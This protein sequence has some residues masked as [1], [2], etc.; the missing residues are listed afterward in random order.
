M[1]DGKNYEDLGDIQIERADDAN[2]PVDIWL[3]QIDKDDDAAEDGRA[4]WWQLRA[5]N[6]MPRRAYLGGERSYY[7]VSKDREVLAALVRK[8]WLPLYQIA[9]DVLTELRPNEDGNARLYY[10]TK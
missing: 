5:N 1:D 8:H 4:G 10:W 3:T 7:A 9:V 2:V 6:Y